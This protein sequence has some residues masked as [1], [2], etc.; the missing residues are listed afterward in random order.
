VKKWLSVGCVLILMMSGCTNDEKEQ[1]SAKENDTEDVSVTE[2]GGEEDTTVAP[3]VI[4]SARGKKIGYHNPIISHHFGADPYVISHDGRVYMYMTYDQLEY[5]GAGNIKEN[6][7]GSIQQLAV[8]SSADLVNWQDHGVIDAAGPTG[9]AKWAT[10]SWAP[11]VAK[12]TI[13][14]QEQ[15]FIYFAN[16]ASGI[17]VLTSDSPTGPFIDPIG[18]PLVSFE[19]PGVEGVT[20][21]FDPA[22]LVDEDQSAYLYFGGGIP[23]DTFEMPNTAR[24]IQ[25]GEDMTSVTGEATMIP[26]PF[27]FE[28]AGIN[29]YQGTYYYSYSTNFY[30]GERPEGSPGAG[31]I[32]YM[33]S[34]SPMGPFEYQHPI[35]KNPGHFFDVGGNNHQVIFDFND[36]WYIAYH[37][38]TLAKDMEAVVGY[39]S[40]HINALMFNEE[41]A[42]EEVT[43]NYE[44]VDQLQAFDP[45]QTVPAET[46]A[47]Q[48]QIETT[49]SDEATTG[50]YVD[51]IESGD[52]LAVSDVDFYDGA[53]LVKA[54]VKPLASGKMELRS[55]SVDGDVVGELTFDG[56][57]NEWVDLEATVNIPKGVTDLYFIFYSEADTDVVMFDTWSFHQ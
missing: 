37:A 1:G 50:V 38:Q 47:W 20:W 53:T 17:G 11:A 34:D 31:E 36:Q 12:K 16:N 8:I 14:G 3:P 27:M 18:E 30:D 21:L 4:S 7:Y 29:K 25:L 49:P 40:P 46:F 54:R 22:V 55:G 9:A 28:S 39:R 5:D 6:S 33:T 57:L 13:N 2:E 19:T 48:A 42:I 24:V 32:A 52:W 51:A 15:F 45:Y 56:S 44:G 43:A 41:G 23:E 10:Q 35:L 26:A